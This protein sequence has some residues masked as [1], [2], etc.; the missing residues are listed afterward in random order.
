MRDASVKNVVKVTE[1]EEI[2]EFHREAS[3]WSPHIIH[4]IAHG[5]ENRRF[6]EPGGYADA[7]GRRSRRIHS[8][9]A[10]A[11]PTL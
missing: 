3:E 2:A 1:S 7:N 4:F 6:S 5:E 11:A 10:E 9:R 8:D